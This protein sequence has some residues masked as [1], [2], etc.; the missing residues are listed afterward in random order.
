MNTQKT[1]QVADMTQSNPQNRAK[2]M[3]I[4]PFEANEIPENAFVPLEIS[5]NE[6]P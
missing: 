4:S 2:S 6:L 3:E 5:H 1:L